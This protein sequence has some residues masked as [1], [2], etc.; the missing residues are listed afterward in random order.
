MRPPHHARRP[1]VTLHGTRKRRDI[2]LGQHPR[3]ERPNQALADV[4]LEL[5]TEA[6]RPLRQEAVCDADEQ[7]DVGHGAELCVGPRREDDRLGDHERD[8][9]DDP[10]A[11]RPAKQR[12]DRGER[13]DR[14]R[15]PHQTHAARNGPGELREVG[16]AERLGRSHQVNQAMH[17][18][19]ERK[20]PAHEE[21]SHP[22]GDRRGSKRPAHLSYPTPLVDG[23]AA[24]RGQTRVWLR[25]RHSASHHSRRTLEWCLAPVL[26]Y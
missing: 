7:K 16:V 22:A 19:D 18:D 23:A 1:E 26:I 15:Q 4:P 24:L 17:C 6:G 21:S 3:V 10:P 20:H 11:A 25:S 8:R 14:R 13:Q 5:G 9:A 2:G 12:C